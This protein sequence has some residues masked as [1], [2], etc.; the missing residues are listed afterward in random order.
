MTPPPGCEGVALGTESCVAS[1]AIAPPVELKTAGV[2][3][4]G[5]RTSSGSRTL[6]PQSLAA[7]LEFLMINLT[8]RV[9]LLKDVEGLGGLRVRACGLSLMLDERP[10]KDAA[11]NQ[12]NQEH[13]GEQEHPSAHPSA[14]RSAATWH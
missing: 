14:H 3:L 1:L 7:L 6:R 5:S 9:P 10:H 13:Q 12:K 4:E 11:Q 8:P 2:E